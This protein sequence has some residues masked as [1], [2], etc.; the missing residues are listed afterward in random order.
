EQS[1]K[2]PRPRIGREKPGRPILTHRRCGPTTCTPVIS[3]LNGAHEKRIAIRVPTTC[4]LR[5]VARWDAD[6]AYVLSRAAPHGRPRAAAGLRV[7]RG[8][9]RP[10]R[11]SRHAAQ[12]G[13]LRDGYLSWHETLYGGS[14]WRL[15]V[16]RLGAKPATVMSGNL[17][18][19]LLAGGAIGG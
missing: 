5:D 3:D 16:A 15:R 10:R 6:V 17:D 18:C 1:R 2:D 11:L 19:C 14:G 9:A 12:L 13:A 7:R 8:H 4:E